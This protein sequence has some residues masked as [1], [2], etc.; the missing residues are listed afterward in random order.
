MEYRRL[1]QTGLKVSVV[2]LGCNNFGM[3]CDEVQ[4][5][6]VIH[7][8]LDH[9]IN[10]F[11]TADAYG[12]TKSEE[13]LGRA[14]KGMDRSQIIIATKFA[15]PLGDGPLRGGASR[16]YIMSAVEASLKRLDT[17]YIDLY[18]QHPL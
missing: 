2:G 10:F 8:A 5:Q 16:Q 15:I 7:A 4:S 11:D 13:F 17:D 1:G 14:V 9:G 3:R 18:Q 6:A 12:G